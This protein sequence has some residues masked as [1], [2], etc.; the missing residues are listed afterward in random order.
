MA[1]NAEKQ[2]WTPS[3]AFERV[4]KSETPPDANVL[5]SH[6]IYKRKLDGHSKARIVPWGTWDAEKRH[7]C[8]CLTT[9]P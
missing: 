8:R 1:F 5:G 4:L 6:V 2:A 7:L 3:K 9:Q